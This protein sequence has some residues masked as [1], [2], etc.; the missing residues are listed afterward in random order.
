MSNIYRCE[1][2]KEI[3]P[4][5]RLVRRITHITY[6]HITNR[7]CITYLILH[8][9]YNILYHTHSHKHYRYVERLHRSDLNVVT[10]DGTNPKNGKLHA[11][12][13]LV[14][15][16]VNTVYIHYTRVM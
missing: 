2:C 11:C 13:L 9:I 15:T 3:A 7:V 5:V 4:S 12:T 6:T 1:V 14:T 16:L 10:L 8:P